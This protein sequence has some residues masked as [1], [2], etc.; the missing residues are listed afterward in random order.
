MVLIFQLI[1]LQG[2]GSHISSVVAWGA[3]PVCGLSLSLVQGRWVNCRS[4]LAGAPQGLCAWNNA[5]MSVSVLKQMSVV[6]LVGCT[7]TTTGHVS[8]NQ[9]QNPSSQGGAQLTTGPV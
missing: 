6:H 8:S 4:K 9:V 2:D 1:A 3:F 5:H 7:V